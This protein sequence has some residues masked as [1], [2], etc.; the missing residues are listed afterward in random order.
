MKQP[1]LLV[2]DGDDEVAVQLRQRYVPDYRVEACG[3]LDAA[4]ALLADLS[5]DDDTVALVLAG[6]SLLAAGGDFFD[7]VHQ[8]HPHAKRAL[9]VQGFA[10]TDPPSA[11]VILGSMA[12]GRIDYY[13]PKPF[14]APDE[15]FHQAISSFLLEWTTE[16]LLVPHTVHI[17]GESWTGRAAYLR[18][19]FSM[20]AVPHAFHLADSAAG[21]EL[22]ARAGPGCR[23]PL[24]VDPGGQAMS[25]P[26][27]AEIA[28]AAGAPMD[29]DDRRFDLAIVGC[30]PAGLSAAVY[31]ASEG[32]RTVV[33]D[34]GGIGG[35]ARSSS[36]IR[37]YLGFPR[38]V[39]G[40]RLAEQ[41]YE[42]ASIFGAT[43]A[44]IQRATSLQRNGDGFE[45][46]LA[47]G[48]AVHA[49]TALVAGGASYRRLDA[50]SLDAF[51]G[52]G[53][54]YGAPGSDAQAFAGAAAFIVGGGNSAGQAALHLARFARRV[55]LV[56]RAETLEAGMS[57]YL[58]RQVEANDN[59]EVRTGTVVVGGGGDGHLQELV[60]QQ[61][62]TGEK[63]TVP[64]DALF[65]LI[66]AR[67]NTDWLP[68]EIARDEAGFLFTGDD[69]RE[70]WALDRA[71]FPLETSLPGVLAAGDVR[72]GSIKRVAS[73][74]GEGS[75]AVQFVHRLLAAEPV[76][77]T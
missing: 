51:T 17:V 2:V 64:A 77:A 60:L 62:A 34:E 9:L 58:V 6:E 63:Q 73:A 48:R 21:R 4:L 71:P 20:C 27:D 28:R 57:Q 50:P 43:F 45:L 44:L 36:L 67:P 70:S 42:Q 16:R 10:W 14:A 8:V 56:I 35:Q 33:I 69:A 65:V 3:E 31:G 1:L 49:A 66:G 25:D 23:L 29:F 12:V 13:V 59:V 74:V 61:R 26:T 54:F 7:R 41:A 15:V 19:V 52:A 68:E 24:I 39:S 30:G 37:N 53:V 32:L 38:G 75:V 40:N 46:T 47:G 11:R 72:H 18:D 22:V 55:A 5:G 76:P